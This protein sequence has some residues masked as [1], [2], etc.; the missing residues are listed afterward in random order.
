VLLTHQSLRQDLLW[1]TL[2]LALIIQCLSRNNISFPIFHIAYDVFASDEHRPVTDRLIHT[3][4]VGRVRPWGDAHIQRDGL[5]PKTLSSSSPGR[6]RTS[7]RPQSSLSSER[8]PS[9]EHWRLNRWL[10]RA[11]AFYTPIHQILSSNPGRDMGH[12]R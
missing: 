12:S 5:R 11:V 3:E 9:C 6:L 1:P 7:I 4:S 10:D 8:P 2:N